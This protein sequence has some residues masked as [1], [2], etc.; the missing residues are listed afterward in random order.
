MFNQYEWNNTQS[1]GFKFA[2][3]TE[4]SVLIAEP[5]G[6]KVLSIKTSGITYNRE[7]FPQDTA[8][9]AAR[10]VYEIM[11]PKTNTFGVTL[12]LDLKLQAYKEFPQQY[13]R[14]NKEGVEYSYDVD[15]WHWWMLEYLNKIVKSSSV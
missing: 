11:K 15:T 8:E 4:P 6:P 14:V 1:L 13:F 5:N 7:Q 10:R 9:Q 3:P 2:E 12:D